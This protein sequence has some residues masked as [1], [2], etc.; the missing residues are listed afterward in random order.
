[1]RDFIVKVSYDI[2]SN[3]RMQQNIKDDFE[4][5]FNHHESIIDVILQQEKAEV[6]GI[7]N[8]WYSKF[9]SRYTDAGAQSIFYGYKLENNVYKMFL[10]RQGANFCSKAI[11][12]LVN[13]IGDL[14]GKVR[15]YWQDNARSANPDATF[16][17]L[18]NNIQVLVRQKFVAGP[19][20]M[21]LMPNQVV[22]V[23]YRDMKELNE[24]IPNVLKG[25]LLR[26]YGIVL[27]AQANNPGLRECGVPV[28]SAT[29]VE[30][31]CG[32]YNGLQDDF[33]IER[34]R[35]QQEITQIR[36][37]CKQLEQNEQNLKSA[38]TAAEQNLEKTKKE[39]QDYKNDL[40]QTLND[41]G[42]LLKMNQDLSHE[43]VEAKKIITK[44]SEQQEFRELEKLLNDVEER[45]QQIAKDGEM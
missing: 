30:S 34:Q 45:L 1:M 9:H 44:I 2:N 26:H 13:H 39:A 11:N 23:T 24:I 32:L 21:P 14:V 33:N 35:M 37:R 31:V 43:L 6:I 28:R 19:V 7:S 42:E 8:L 3:R 38:K 20:V 17:Q 5:I 25:Q 22:I 36:A 4:S 15:R 12:T 41:L 40:L 16:N 27:F 29:Q 10:A 18:V